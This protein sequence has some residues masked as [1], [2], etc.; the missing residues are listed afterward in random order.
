V[1]WGAVFIYQVLLPLPEG[2]FRFNWRSNWFCGLG[3]YCVAL[4]LVVV[5]LINQQLAGRG[6][7][8]LLSLALEGQDQVALAILRRDR[9]P[10]I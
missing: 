6:S 9:C 2:W 5:S 3:G 8:P 7:N 10:I 1:H 4:P